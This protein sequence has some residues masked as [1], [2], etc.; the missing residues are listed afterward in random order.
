ML[1]L[2]PPNR[3]VTETYAAC[4]SRVRDADLRLRL[5]NAAGAVEAASDAFAVAAAA[6]ELH[7][8]AR[9]ATVGAV[10]RA[11]MEA[12][13]VQRMAKK[14]APGRAIYEELISTPLHGRCPICAQRSVTTLDHHLPKAHYPALAVTPLNLVPSCSDCNKAKLA[15]FPQTAA[16]VSLHPYF[17]DVDS[18]RWLFATVIELQPTALTFYVDA[19][20]NF[21]DTLV[22]RLENHFEAFGLGHLYAAEAA[23][24][25]LNV[26]FQLDILLSTAGPDTVKAH[27]EDEAASRRNARLNGW[28]TAAYEAW[29]ASDWFCE[30]GFNPIG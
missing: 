28:R 15:G 25:L 2:E 4:I 30:G 24:E 6:Q 17:D 9:S 1:K 26:R 12:V 19:P 21:D 16:E 20:D 22:E 8:I 5:Q 3:T 10:S 18:E 23:E 13:Y 14:G 11:E 29:A 7:Q 27:L